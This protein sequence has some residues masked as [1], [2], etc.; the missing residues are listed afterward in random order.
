MINMNQSVCLLILDGWGHAPADPKNAISQAHTPRYDRLLTASEFRTLQ[1]S[2]MHVGLPDNQFGNSEVGHLTIGAGQIVESDLTRIEK[3]LS[4]KAIL[5]FLNPG[6]IHITGLFSCGGVHSHIRHIIKLIEILLAETTKNIFLHMIT[7]GRDRPIDAFSSDN[8]K[9]IALTKN[10]SERIKVAS[11]AG[12]YF[13]MDRDRNWER[14]ECAS[15]SII[16]SEHFDFDQ[17]LEQHIQSGISDEFVKPI[18]LNASQITPTDTFIACNFRADRMAQ[19]I[20]HL[21]NKFPAKYLIFGDYPLTKDA[22]NIFP[23]QTIED[24]LG[25]VVSEA[26]LN[27]LRITETEKFAHVTYFFNA[28]NQEPLANETRILIPSA[29]VASFDHKPEMSAFAIKDELIANLPDHQLLI[30]NLPNADMVGHTGNLDATIKA[31]ET[32]D[33]CIG[34][35]SEACAQHNVTLLITADHGNA[36]EMLHPDGSASTTHSLAK[37]PFLLIGSQRKLKTNLPEAS[38]ANI[39]PTILD[40][41]NLNIP[42]SMTESLVCP[43]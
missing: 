15:E 11:I 10:N 7:D 33:T 2:A 34:Q 27:Q 29:K 30:C 5:P 8:Q 39:A 13:A 32:L 35:I 38:L 17:W 23:K 36:D 22:L 6:D 24:T 41:M 19:L 20:S 1:A 43:S 4:A 3:Q 9:L 37:V 26:G 12:R 25:S 40:L 14:T 18:S 31:I 21:E 16:S 28:L 42:K